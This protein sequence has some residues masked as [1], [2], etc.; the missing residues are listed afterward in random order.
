MKFFNHQIQ[1]NKISDYAHS[2]MK[3]IFKILNEESTAKVVI[4]LL[5][6]INLILQSEE[7]SNKVNDQ[8]IVSHLIK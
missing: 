8:T 7:I 6:I 4:N 3:F 5:Q 1:E 2:F